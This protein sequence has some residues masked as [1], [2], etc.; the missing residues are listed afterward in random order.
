MKKK[1][2]SDWGFGG[3]RVIK[4]SDLIKFNLKNA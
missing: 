1:K 4:E 3:L 2:L